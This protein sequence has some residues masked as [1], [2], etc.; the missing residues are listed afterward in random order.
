MGLPLSITGLSVSSK[1]G[2]LLLSVP[3]LDLPAGSLVGIVGASGA[4]KS[5]LLYSL[6]GLLEAEGKICWGD[7]DLLGLNSEQRAGF[8]ADKIGMIFQDFLLFEELNAGENASLTALFRPRRERATLRTKAAERLEF[9]GLGGETKDR[10]VVSLSGGERQRVA[11]A[12]AMAAQAPVL[13]ADEPTASLDRAAANRLIED[14]V[15][16]ARSSGTTL[17]AVS[18]DQS[19]ISRMDRVLTISDG[20]ISGD[21]KAAT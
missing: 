16:L 14:L 6:A 19:L 4:G 17:I 3:E 18:H 15:N 5:T 8:R 11:I 9:L 21:R 13:L 7:Q 20:I 12:R 1:R 2:R 10:N